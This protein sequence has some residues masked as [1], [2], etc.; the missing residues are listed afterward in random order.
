LLLC[1]DDRSWG[2]V[3]RR[4]LGACEGIEVVGHASDGVEAL[5]M[6]RDLRPD[7]VVTDLAMAPLDGFE[8]TAAIRSA[9]PG[10]RLVV[11]SG[12]DPVRAANGAADAGA[13][14]FVQKG[15]PLEELIAAVELLAA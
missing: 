3:L 4:L 2:I 7:I 9:H 5:R 13:D 14:M 6:V 10:V 1:D 12:M 15:A 11:F 8:V